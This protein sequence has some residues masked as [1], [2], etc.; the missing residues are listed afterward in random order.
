MGT[1]AFSI[2]QFN[3]RNNSYSP[4]GSQEI[5]KPLRAHSC[6]REA[7]FHTLQILQDHSIFFFCCSYPRGHFINSFLQDIPVCIT[8]AGWGEKGFVRNALY[9]WSLVP[10]CRNA[11]ASFPNMHSIFHIISCDLHL[12]SDTTAGWNSWQWGVQTNR[13]QYFCKMWSEWR[14]AMNTV[15]RRH[16]SEKC[17]PADFPGAC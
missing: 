16:L 3:R 1:D 17:S 4:R 10:C 14:W 5:M 7:L 15:L 9:R 8:S 12:P 11:K 6:L 13:F 2:K